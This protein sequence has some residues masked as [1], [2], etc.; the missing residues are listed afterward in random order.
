MSKIRK[1]I[2]K[3]IRQSYPDEISFERFVIVYL[4]ALMFYFVDTYGLS[5]RTVLKTILEAL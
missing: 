2:F 5:Q 3:M 4:G 1:K